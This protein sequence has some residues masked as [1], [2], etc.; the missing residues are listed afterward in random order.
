MSVLCTLI[1]RWGMKLL[2]RQSH[3]DDNSQKVWNLNLQWPRQSLKN[4]GASQHDGGGV[5][6]ILKRR[7]R[8]GGLIAHTTPS[9]FPNHFTANL[10][11]LTFMIQPSGWWKNKLIFKRVWILTTYLLF[12]QRMDSHADHSLD[13]SQ[14]WRPMEHFKSCIF[15]LRMWQ[16][17]WITM[18]WIRDIIFYWCQTL[19]TRFMNAQQ[20]VRTVFPKV[21]TI[22]CRMSANWMRW[23]HDYV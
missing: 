17:R 14:Q 12:T 18:L 6:L 3:Y 7:S 10:H 4:T 15:F 16:T 19:L 20:L 13:W 9:A 11:W 22:E 1:S 5:R 8:C 21:S 23:K 2:Q